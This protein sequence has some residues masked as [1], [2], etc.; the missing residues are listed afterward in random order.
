MR[1]LSKRVSTCLPAESALA[2][3]RM[4]MTPMGVST[5]EVMSLMSVPGP[6]PASCTRLNLPTNAGNSSR[7]P[8]YVQLVRPIRVRACGS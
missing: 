5:M 2:D 6:M 1:V 3:S 4:V 7:T 8:P